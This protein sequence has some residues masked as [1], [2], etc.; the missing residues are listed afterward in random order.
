MVYAFVDSTRREQIR[1]EKIIE[2]QEQHLRDLQAQLDELRRQ[3]ALELE[4]KKVFVADAIAIAGEY[5]LFA[6]K[7]NKDVAKG[8]EILRQAK[9]QLKLDNYDSALDLAKQ[10][11]EFFRLAR[12]LPPKRRP[13]PIFYKVRWHDTLWSI[14]E[15]PKH[16]GKGS[17]WPKIWF[18]NMDKINN[19][20]LIYPDQVFLIKKAKS[21]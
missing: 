12:L 14:A 21:K 1:Q 18:L 13:G 20:G 5:W 11:M 19:P 6:K 15:M 3:A 8:Q 4:K 7:E 10:S 9:E 16:Y 17:M 2:Q